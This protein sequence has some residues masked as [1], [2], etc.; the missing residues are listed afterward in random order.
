MEE[1]FLN[2]LG[3]KIGQSIGQF[4]MSVEGVLKCCTKLPSSHYAKCVLE[5]QKERE[6]GRGRRTDLVTE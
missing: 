4:G 5:G 1:N 6:S 2:G 3:G